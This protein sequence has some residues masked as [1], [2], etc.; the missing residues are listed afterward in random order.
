MRRRRERSTGQRVTQTGKVSQQA[1]WKQGC[2]GL[3]GCMSVLGLMG[4]DERQPVSSESSAETVQT[5]TETETSSD[6]TPERAE[7][8]TPVQLPEAVDIWQ[9]PEQVVLG[10]VPLHL[11]S[12]LW[13][14]S[15]PVIG[16]D[17]ANPARK[18]FASIRLL[19]A[20]HQPLPK[21]I[22]ITQVL[23]EQ[24]DEQWL[25]QQHLE[26][27]KDGNKS[28]EVALRGG[29]EWQPSSTVNVAV[30]VLFQGQEHTV[31]QKQVVIAQVF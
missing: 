31:I 25:V 14:N 17:G 19:A 5:E 22:E 24:G 29:P 30:T 12:E 9:S 23:I 10:E 27:R 20:D 8:S 7:S 26:I 21:G 18:L 6:K 11:G 28:L 1:A 15:M 13:L 3:L 4:C 2:I 16:D